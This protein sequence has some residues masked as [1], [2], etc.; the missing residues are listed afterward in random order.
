[1]NLQESSLLRNLGDPGT[2]SIQAIPQLFQ[3]GQIYL[4]T[5]SPSWTGNVI[6]RHNYDSIIASQG[7]TNSGGDL[8]K[9]KDSPAAIMEL[10]RIT[11]L[12]ID[13]LATIFGV[14]RRS[15]HFWMSG[16]KLHPSNEKKLNHV[17]AIIQ[18]IDQGSAYLNRQMLTEPIENKGTAVELLSAGRFSDVIEAFVEKPPRYQFK[19]PPLSVKARM[20]R[21]PQKPE[22]LA[23]AIQEPIALK[24]GEVRFGKSFK[25][26]PR[27]GKFK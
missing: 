21:L 10:R 9:L 22:L 18:R 3:R 13:Q 26:R 5:L 4:L 11:G 25:V 27:R 24:R 2:F 14:S 6:G 7:Q 12:T 17:L 19:L 15:L 20:A 16:E 23:D 1:M 8:P